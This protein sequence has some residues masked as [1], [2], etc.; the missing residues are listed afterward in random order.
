MV[1][2]SLIEYGLIWRFAVKVAFGFKSQGTEEIEFFS[3]GTDDSINLR[4]ESLITSGYKCKEIPVL[5][6]WM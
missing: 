3:Q 2:K 1:I 6:S 5:L 4:Y